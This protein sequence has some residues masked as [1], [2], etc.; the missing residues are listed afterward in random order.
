MSNAAQKRYRNRNPTHNN[1]VSLV[2]MHQIIPT[3][4]QNDRNKYIKHPN[5]IC[6]RIWFCSEFQYVFA[7]LDC[8]LCRG[9]VFVN[10]PYDIPGEFIENFVYA[11]DISCIEDKL[12][13]QALANLFFVLVF[14]WSKHKHKHKQTKPLHQHHLP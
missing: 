14:C 4:S 7:R 5:H 9:V 11:V 12:T 2:P 10:T 6:L 1:I 3:N 8:S 13:A